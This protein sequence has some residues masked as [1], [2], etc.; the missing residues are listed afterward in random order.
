MQI[1]IRM[2]LRTEALALMGWRFVFLALLF[3]AGA[4]CSSFSRDW[5]SAAAP[6]AQGQTIHGR[7][8]GSWLSKTNGHHGRLRCVL[9]EKTQDQY[10]AH[11]HANFWKIFSYSYTVPLMVRAE[12]GAYRFEGEANLGWW[13]G[14][15]Y[16]YQGEASP[17]NFF[18]LYQSKGDGGTFQMKRPVGYVPG[19]QN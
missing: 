18:S 10:Q 13:A 19:T 5:K 4:G 8:D 9:R 1:A 7:W 15:S 14:G 16:H 17:T 12:G 3:W 11:F 6:P 2:V